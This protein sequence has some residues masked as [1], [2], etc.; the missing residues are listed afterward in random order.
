MHPLRGLLHRAPGYVW[1]NSDEIARLAEHRGE[2]VEAFALKFVRRVG[3]RLSLIERPGGDCIFWDRQVGCTVYPARPAQCQTW[4]FWPENLASPEDW[5][6]VTGIC[7]GSGRGRLFSV[8][9]IRRPPR[10]STPH[11]PPR[12][13][14]RRPGRRPVPRTPPRG[15]RRGRRGGRA[16]GPRLRDQRPLLPVRGVRPHPVRLGA[17]V[18]SLAGRRPAAVPADRRRRD[19]PLAGRARSLH[20]PGS[21]AD[22]LPGLLLRSELPGRTRP[23]SPRPG[24]P[25]SSGW[26]TTSAC[27][28]T[29]PPSTVIFTRPRPSDAIRQPTR[30]PKALEGALTHP[31]KPRFWTLRPF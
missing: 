8:E 3:Q 5:E 1:V 10:E 25:G 11:E 29:T 4:P 6:D 16:P 21:P 9:E 17:R 2:S 27:P 23:R 22:R 15:L 30:S 14:D 18:R 31:V 13:L 26:S 28:G 20:R 19:L 24:S 12:R 7:P